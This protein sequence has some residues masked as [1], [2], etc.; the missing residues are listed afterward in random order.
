M[1]NEVRLCPR[2]TGNEPSVATQAAHGDAVGSRAGP[3]RS[4]PTAAHGRRANPSAA[5]ST[6]SSTVSTVGGAASRAGPWPRRAARP[7]CA[8]GAPARRGAASATGTVSFAPES[9]RTSVTTPAARSRGPTSTRTGT[10]FSSQS[11]TRRPKL[12]GR[13][14]RR[15]RTRTPTPSS[16]RGESLGGLAGAVLVPDEQHDDLDGREAGR[17]PQAGVVA[18][19][20][21]QAADHPGRRRPTTSSS[22]YSSVADSRRGTGSRTPWRS[23]GPS[24]WLVPICSALPS[25]IIASTR[26]RVDRAGEPLAGGL[27]AGQHRDGEHVRP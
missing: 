7:G 6:A 25:P 2:S 9:R 11:T 10:P 21:D 24:S 17:D 22:T 13:C 12:T 27:A 5:A 19:A 8:R 1:A 23:S 20:H 15:A 26:Q 3:R 14:G 18:V 4:A 16:S